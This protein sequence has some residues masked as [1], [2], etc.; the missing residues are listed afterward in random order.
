MNRTRQNII[1]LGIYTLLIIGII[2]AG[3][4][5]Y[6]EIQTGDGCPKIWLIPAC[7]IVL[8]CF[9]VPFF[10]H[11]TNKK[12]TLYFIFT[13]IAWAIAIFATILNFTGNG[14]CPQLDNGTPMCYISLIIFS[15]LIILK[16][17][18]LKKR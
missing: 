10:V 14:K 11:L 15:L 4:L 5:V 12:I 13:G 6:D 3:E 1:N 17:L 2:G 9:V 8:I 18:H 7:I 16:K